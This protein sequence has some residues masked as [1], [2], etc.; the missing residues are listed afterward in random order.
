M[1]KEVFQTDNNGLY[2]YPCMANELAITPGVFNIPFGAF[3][4]AAPVPP[5]GKWPRRVGDAWVMVDDHRTTPL[6]VVDTGLPYRV[7]SDH[8]G[9][10][11]KVS[12]LGWGTLPG[13]L[14]T[15][16]PQQPAEGNAGG[17]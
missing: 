16:D 13:W 14:T 11:G 15:V 5:A 6:W 2:L 7:G 8:D 17:A 1:Q 10:D 12:Y 3:E 4:E 9:A